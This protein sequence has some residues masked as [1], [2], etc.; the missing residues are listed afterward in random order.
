MSSVQSF[1][2]NIC[3]GPPIENGLH[4]V[5]LAPAV[6]YLN[7]FITPKR[8]NAGADLLV[9][10]PGRRSSEETSQRWRAIGYTVSDYTGPGIEPKAFSADR[11]S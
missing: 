2:I 5:C 8:I 10:V 11:M 9:L 4:N 6:P 7:L 3:N 1:M